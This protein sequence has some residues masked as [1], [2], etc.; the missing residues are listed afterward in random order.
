M[1]K[2]NHRFE[3]EWRRVTDRAVDDMLNAIQQ[4]VSMRA[5]DEDEDTVALALAERICLAKITMEHGFDGVVL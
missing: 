4:V 1:G 5:K 3:P 2:V